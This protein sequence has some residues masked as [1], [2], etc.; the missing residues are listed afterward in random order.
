M[1]RQKSE[2]LSLAFSEQIHNV[3]IGTWPCL[4]SSWLTMTPKCGSWGQ[5]YYGPSIITLLPSNICEHYCWGQTMENLPY[6]FPQKHYSITSCSS[7]SPR[8]F[9]RLLVILC[10]YLKL[11]SVATSVHFDLTP[12]LWKIQLCIL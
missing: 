7:S 4:Q 2:I 11:I 1:I 9:R 6:T 8:A 12:S 3:V 5:K 10:P